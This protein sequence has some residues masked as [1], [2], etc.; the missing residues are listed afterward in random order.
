MKERRDNL[1][2]TCDIL[3]TI[4]EHGDKIPQGHYKVING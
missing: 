2:I 4:A 3:T 1:E